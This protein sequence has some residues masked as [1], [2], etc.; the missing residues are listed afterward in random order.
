MR[1]RIIIISALTILI[2]IIG[3]STGIFWDNKTF[4][5]SMG[6]VLYEKGIFAWDSFPIDF[7]PGQPPFIAT[8]VAA[9]W[10]FFGRT[11]FIS[12]IVIVPF[13]FGILWQ[14]WSLCDFFIDNKK[15]RIYAFFLVIA[16]ATQLSQMTL[17]TPEV[18]L[19]FFFFMSLNALLRDNNI[20][21]AIGLFFLGI[22]SLRGMMLCGGL[23]V[24]DLLLNKR[25]I[26]WK[27]YI[28]GALPAVSFIV[29]R[30]TTKGWIISNPYSN[31][32]NP[33]EY[34]SLMGFLKNLVWNS[35][36]LCQRIM[37]FGRVV[38]L[39]FILFTLVLRRGWQKAEY[40]RLFIIAVA[41]TSVIWV[42]SLFIVN[43]MGHRY[44]IVS[45]MLLMLL[46]FKML[47]EYARRW[48]IYCVLI[49]S[50]LAGNFI[51]YPESMAQGW[52]ASL[53]QLNYWSVRHDMIEYM[54]KN[55]IAINKTAT[56]FPNE[57]KIDDVDIN[58][59][60][61][62][63]AEYT[64]KEQYVFYSNVFNLPDEQIDYLHKNYRM[65]KC[66]N[67]LGVRTELYERIEK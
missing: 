42:V 19:L 63:W 54:D 43:T 34:G 65:T 58:N 52:N 48:A 44:F 14:V 4:V 29:W 57:G 26:S 1:K 59:D 2:A 32:G 51:I 28:I 24:I 62:T 7:D 49:V 8:L 17:I 46:A 15:D 31:W 50:L 47:R 27:P 38:P 39:M 6:N 66:F 60:Q 3:M 64:G 23:F 56:F 61:R 35:A 5:T 21:K 10:R 18:P 25:Q 12:H 30:L 41:S 36:V 13:I 67:R 11:L 45:Y 53:A 9:A 40:R 22:V 55:G 20:L 16:D 33:T 37:D